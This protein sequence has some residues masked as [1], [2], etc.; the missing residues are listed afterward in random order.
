MVKRDGAETRR[1]RIAQIARM[2]QAALHA[3]ENGEI[4]LSKFVAGVMYQTGL[5]KEKVREYMEI[6]M[7]M[8]QFELD[9][10]N[11]IIRSP[12]TSV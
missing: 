8:G 10:V 5:T 9:D 12:Q 11:D 3:S 6:P 7:T 1:Q 4:S 2:V